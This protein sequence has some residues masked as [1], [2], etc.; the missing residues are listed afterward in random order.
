V[1]PAQFLT[2][3]RCEQVTED[4]WILLEPLRYYSAV[5]EREIAVPAGFITDYASVPRL[6]FIYWFTGGLAAAPAVLHDWLYRTDS[7]DVSRAQADAVLAEAMGVRGYWK[8]RSWF[9]WAGV[10]I[11][12]H[13]SFETRSAHA[14]SPL[15]E[16][17]KQ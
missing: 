5:L 3:L 2:P 6:P 15:P 12:G 17:T 1:R 8:A 10:R 13:W 14:P 4:D 9:M 11:G 16:P 7:Q